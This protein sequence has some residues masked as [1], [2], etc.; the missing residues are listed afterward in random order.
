MLETVALLPREVKVSMSS[1]SDAM[2]FHMFFGQRHHS[3]STNLRI[4]FT[5]QQKARATIGLVSSPF[6]RH[7]KS[8][9]TPDASGVQ[10]LLPD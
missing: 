2:A 4:G 10:N 3:I 6:S 1:T 5:S 7:L 9:E 8:M